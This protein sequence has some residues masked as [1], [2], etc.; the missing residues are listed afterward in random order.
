MTF[1]N[2]FILFLE[3]LFL[4]FNQM[5]SIW[6]FSRRGNQFTATDT[7]YFDRPHQN[8]LNVADTPYIDSVH[9]NKLTVTETPYIDSVISSL[10]QIHLTLIDYTK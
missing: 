7:P 3:Q 10:L 6:A 4:I 1:P 2:F 8:K 9:Q 5:L